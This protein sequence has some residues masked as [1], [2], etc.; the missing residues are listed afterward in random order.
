M[1]YI[2][3]LAIQTFR[4]LVSVDIEPG[5]SFN[6]FIGENGSGKTSLL[7]SIS[8]LAHGRSFRTHKFRRLIQYDAPQLT[9][10]ARLQETK[11]EDQ[12]QR[13]IGVMRDAK[14]G[15]LI[16]VDGSNAQSAAELAQALP[17]LVMNASSF[18]LLEG[19]PKVRRQFFDWL[20]FHVEHQF[21]DAWKHYAR[22]VKQRNSLLRHAKIS[23]PELDPWDQEVARYGAVIERCRQRVFT[24]YQLAVRDS[25]NL[26]EFVSELDS[27][28]HGLQLNY[29]DGWK[30]GEGE[31]PDVERYCQVLQQTRERD[32][33]LGYTSIGSHKSD[34]QLYSGKIPAV[35]SLSRGQQKSVITG[36]Y[37]AQAQLFNQL[38]GR[39]PVFLLDDLPSELDARNLA[40]V[41]R[42]LSAMASQVFITAISEQSLQT[43]W[44]G[45]PQQEFKMFHVEHGSITDVPQLRSE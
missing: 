44:G 26:F 10:F 19:A 3:R 8:V 9:L 37:L 35:E 2:T 28:G 29:L 25:F 31:E 32:L 30:L 4:N 45:L 24:E 14:G 39:H 38:S 40:V 21:R 11:D 6:I 42:A 20:V 18:L 36:L 5:A 27:S 12:L 7:E 23:G 41:E 16:K 22:C 17:L 1:P 13:T 34:L 15:S 33:K 43:E